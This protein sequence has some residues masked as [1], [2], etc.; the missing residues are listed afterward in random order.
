M[1]CRTGCAGCDPL[2]VEHSVHGG[3]IYGINLYHFCNGRIC[4]CKKKIHRTWILIYTDRVC[5]GAS[6]TGDSD[7]AAPGDVQLKA[8]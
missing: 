1:Y 2:A 7:P 8:V 5:N 3:C 4:T 6:E